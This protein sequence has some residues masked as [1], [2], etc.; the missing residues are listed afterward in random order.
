MSSLSSHVPSGS[1]GE[2]I[3]IYI[4][5]LGEERREKVLRGSLVLKS[6]NCVRFLKP[7]YDHVGYG[8][9]SRGTENQA[10]DI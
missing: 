5:Q 6:E 2:V 10:G 8:R 7:S 9:D 3:Y 4:S 1:R